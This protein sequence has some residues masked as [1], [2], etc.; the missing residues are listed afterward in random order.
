MVLKE[1]EL[2]GPYS[3]TDAENG[4]AFLF[5]CERIL[6][7]QRIECALGDFV[8]RGGKELDQVSMGYGADC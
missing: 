1:K 3:W 6:H 7:S 4:E 2:G 8:T 5:I